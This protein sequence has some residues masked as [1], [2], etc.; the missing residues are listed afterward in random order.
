MQYYFQTIDVSNTNLDTLLRFPVSSKPVSGI[1]LNNIADAFK[2][3]KLPENIRNRT[4]NRNPFQHHVN[5]LREILKVD[6]KG[7]DTMIISY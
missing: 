1:P 6:R 2:D 3:V 4:A 7:E 5:Q